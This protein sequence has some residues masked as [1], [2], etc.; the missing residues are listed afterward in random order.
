[1][2]TTLGIYKPCGRTRCTGAERRSAERYRRERD[3]QCGCPVRLKIFLPVLGALVLAFVM[4][5]LA[6]RALVGMTL[7]QKVDESG[8]RRYLQPYG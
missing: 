1:M 8:G 6:G 4:V 2:I 7:N 5:H 3:S